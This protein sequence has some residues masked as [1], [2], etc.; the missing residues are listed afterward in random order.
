[1]GS[2]G[3]VEEKSF[4]E[5]VKTR[6]SGPLICMAMTTGNP[7]MLEGNTFKRVLDWTSGVK[8]RK[9]LGSAPNLFWVNPPKFFCLGG[10]S[11]CCVDH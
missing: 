4:K 1:M 11:D 10:I 5:E 9:T 6:T 7:V 3:L 2:C 8:V